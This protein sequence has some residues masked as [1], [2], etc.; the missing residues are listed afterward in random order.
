MKYVEII[1]TRQLLVRLLF[2][3]ITQI[4]KLKFMG[5]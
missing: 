2:L 5:L 4:F 1:R 3:L